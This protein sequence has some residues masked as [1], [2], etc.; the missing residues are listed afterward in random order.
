MTRRNPKRNER[1]RLSFSDTESGSQ[2]LLMNDSIV[3]AFRCAE[4]PELAKKSGAAEDV[5]IKAGES[6]SVLQDATADKGA[7]DIKAH[8]AN[9]LGQ[10]LDRGQKAAPLRMLD[11][12][13]VF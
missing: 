12:H 1:Q 10:I 2:N 9:E 11:G 8:L 7:A 3:G 13:K 6:V 5:I 4:L